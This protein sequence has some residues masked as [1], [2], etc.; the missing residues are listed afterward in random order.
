MVRRCL[1]CDHEF[2]P[3]FD[4]DAFCSTY[5]TNFWW[6]SA[7]AAREW[8]VV[9]RAYRDDWIKTVPGTR[10]THSHYGQGTVIRP[11][12]QFKIVVRFD[13]KALFS[14]GRA[15]QIMRYEI[16]PT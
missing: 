10:V 3:A 4:T 14:Q 12:G 16:T 8:E 15:V 11:E 9:E 13:N 5:C 1:N 2:E 6:M 7:T